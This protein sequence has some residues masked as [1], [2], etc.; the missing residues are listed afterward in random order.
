MTD[1]VSCYLVLNALCLFK[2]RSFGLLCYSRCDRVASGFCC[3]CMLRVGSMTRVLVRRERDGIH[4]RSRLDSRNRKRGR[5]EFRPSIPGSPLAQCGHSKAVGKRFFVFWLL[6]FLC[7]SRCPR[8]WLWCLVPS[9]VSVVLF[10]AVGSCLVFS[11]G[12][13]SLF[14]S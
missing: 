13:G 12:L 4:R 2:K 14:V 6:S 11:S 8:L 9:S 5:F 1:C 7:G 3:A 10:P